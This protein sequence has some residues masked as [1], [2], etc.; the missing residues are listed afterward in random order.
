MVAESGSGGGTSS[1]S[2]GAIGAPITRPSVRLSDACATAMSRS[3]AIRSF[4]RL[5]DADLGLDDVEPRRAAGVEAR[6]R[7]RE[8]IVRQRRA[9]RAD[10]RDA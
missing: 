6:L 10:S 7:A 2:V 5:R 8:K 3:L 1:E 4:C 9:P